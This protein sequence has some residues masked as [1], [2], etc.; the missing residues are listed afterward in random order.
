MC[1]S[2]EAHPFCSAQHLFLLQSPIALT[3]VDKL[4][5]AIAVN[6]CTRQLLNWCRPRA[7]ARSRSS[8][9]LTAS[10]TAQSLHCFYHEASTGIWVR[11]LPP[12]MV[13]PTSISAAETR[14]SLP[15]RGG[16]ELLFDKQKAHD[17]D[18]PTPD[19]S[20]VRPPLPATNQLPARAPGTTMPHVP[21]GCPAA[22]CTSLFARM[23][24]RFG[25]PDAPLTRS[26]RWPPR[27]R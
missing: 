24:R 12:P 15:C 25:P 3:S 20:Q 13:H 19:P 5:K 26:L 1:L 17:V 7:E 8:K 4:N 14:Q 9:L 2:F 10:I 22:R 11:P 23:C 16:L 21:A 27:R 6:F 18:V